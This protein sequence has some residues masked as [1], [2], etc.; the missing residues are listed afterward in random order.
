MKIICGSSN[1]RV[2]K[3][4]VV[5]LLLTIVS[6]SLIGCE[7][8]DLFIPKQN[9]LLDENCRPIPE[10]F[11]A[12]WKKYSDIDSA[13]PAESRSIEGQEYF[14]KESEIATLSAEVFTL[15]RD[16]EVVNAL[17]AELQQYHVQLKAGHKANLIKTTV[18]MAYITYQ[19]IDSAKGTGKLYSEFLTEGAESGVEL[20]GKAI[21]LAR[22]VTPG[23]SSIAI[24]TKTL[25]GKVKDVA[26]TGWVEAMASMGDPKE[27]A[28]EMINSAS[29]HILPNAELSDQELSILRREHLE[30]KRIDQLIQESNKANLDRL[31]TIRGKEAQIEKLKG[32]LWEAEMKEKDRVRE[33]LVS[34]C[35]RNKKI[36]GKDE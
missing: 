1:T 17:I 4:L 32:E 30:I 36:S 12:E 5:I 31:W 28:Q 11:N 29:S 16:Y 25:D 35:K 15:K 10:K 26:L 18:R 6:I 8:L 7:I 9:P 33:M 3:A 13:I 21:K 19:T 24:N 27:V 22:A 23:E 2:A 34:E 20:T 14:T